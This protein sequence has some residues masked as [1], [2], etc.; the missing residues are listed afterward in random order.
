MAYSGLTVDFAQEQEAKVIIR[1]IRTVKDFD[2]DHITLVVN[3]TPVYAATSIEMRAG[4]ETDEMECRAGVDEKAELIGF[5]S[6]QKV[7]S[8]YHDRLNK[9]K[10]AE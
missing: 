9:L 7:N 4:D 8:D 5:D 2:L 1:G 10:Q 6:T 3:K